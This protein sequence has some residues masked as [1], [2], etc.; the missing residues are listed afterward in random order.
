M[1]PNYVDFLWEFKILFS[2]VK[3]H[4]TDIAIKLRKVCLCIITKIII[5]EPV[6][7]NLN[8]LL[9]LFFLMSINYKLNVTTTIS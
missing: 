9:I 8:K 3:F 2:Q 5:Y 7:A 4:M 1:F 6:I